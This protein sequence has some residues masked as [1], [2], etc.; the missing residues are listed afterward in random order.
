MYPVT[1][2][3]S[4][5]DNKSNKDIC[6]YNKCLYY[7]HIAYCFLE[8]ADPSSSEARSILLYFFYGKPVV[9]GKEMTCIKVIHAAMQSGTYRYDHANICIGSHA[10]TR[11]ITYVIAYE[12]MH[13]CIGYHAYTRYRFQDPAVTFKRLFNFLKAYPIAE[14][15]MIDRGENKVD[16]PMYN[17]FLS[18]VEQGMRKLAK[19]GS[20]IFKANDYASPEAWRKVDKWRRHKVYICMYR[21]YK[22]RGSFAP[23]YKFK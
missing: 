18:V 23:F 6:N 7:F 4:D 8:G 13:K 3:A 22:E 14:K 9:R 5:P 2:P 12:H 16:S 21:K 10:S 17:K 1:V 19:S 11:R 15:W 20:K